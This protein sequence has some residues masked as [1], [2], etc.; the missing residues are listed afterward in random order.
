MNNEYHVFVD[1]DAGRCGTILRHI[2]PRRMRTRTALRM[3]QDAPIYLVDHLV[4]HEGDVRQWRRFTYHSPTSGSQHS[5]TRD[6]DGAVSVDGTSAPTLSSAVGGYSEHL[7]LAQMLLDGEDSVSYLQ[8]AESDP[9]DG[10]QPAELHRRGTEET[11]LLDGSVVDAEL[12][13]LVVAGRVTNAHWCVGG[14]VVKSDW[15]GAQSF[16]VDDLDNLGAGLDAE[17][18]ALIRQFTRQS[19]DEPIV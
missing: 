10:A 16:L 15:C 19:A 7:V 6:P 5:G 13:E 2:E 18:G 1:G 12:V 17:V 8:F 11:E 9:G 14:V 4:E 3:G